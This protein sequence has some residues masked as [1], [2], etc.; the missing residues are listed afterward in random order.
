MLA[1]TI[2]MLFLSGPGPVILAVG[3][4]LLFGI[5]GGTSAVGNQTALYAQAPADTIGTASGLFRTFVYT[6]SIASATITGLVFH[7]SVT[8]AGLHTIAAIL[9]AVGVVVL[10]MSIFDPALSKEPQ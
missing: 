10:A 8:D 3:I 4:T 9:V 1:A 7:T 2:G 6:G 5:V